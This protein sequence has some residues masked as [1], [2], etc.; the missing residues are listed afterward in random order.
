MLDVS[1]S[2]HVV[3]RVE[4][5]TTSESSSPR[6]VHELGVE[7]LPLVPGT[8]TGTI[9]VQ[10]RKGKLR[11]VGALVPDPKPIRCGACS[12]R[13][14]P[15]EPEVWT[16]WHD[17]SE[18]GLRAMYHYVQC[19]DAPPCHVG[20]CCATPAEAVAAW[21]QK[22][23]R[24][25]RCYDDT[26]RRIKKLTA[27]RRSARTRRQVRS[28]WKRGGHQHW[29]ALLAGRV[30]EPIIFDQLGRSWPSDVLGRNSCDT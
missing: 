27:K 9:T 22:V 20:D 18:G 23:V 13:D 26:G 12:F 14:I 30:T 10:L 15:L 3:G 28:D 8:A 21:N 16:R 2:G 19:G 4:S 1:V 24:H 25:G 29:E 7:S 6:A 17:G 5:W 11:H